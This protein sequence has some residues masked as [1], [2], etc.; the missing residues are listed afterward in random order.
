MKCSV[1]VVVKK[2][3]EKKLR[4]LLLKARKR[5]VGQVFVVAVGGFNVVGKTSGVERGKYTLAVGR[6]Q[7]GQPSAALSYRCA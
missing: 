3:K 7:P 4:N 1:V 2:N 5:S 6:L